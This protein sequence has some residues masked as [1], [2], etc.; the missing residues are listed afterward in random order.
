MAVAW[1]PGCMSEDE[2]A[3]WKEMAARVR[4]GGR[5]PCIDC[6]R[7]FAASMGECCNGVPDANRLGRP[8]PELLASR[9]LA[10]RLWRARNVEE[11]RAADRDYY[12]RKKVSA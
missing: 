9:R 10:R 11:R 7:A 5:K 3:A 1:K 12:R 6:P 2:L 4:N 8:S